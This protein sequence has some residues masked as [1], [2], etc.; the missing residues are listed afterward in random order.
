MNQ[1]EFD[2]FISYASEDRET[3]VEPLIQMLTALGVRV[4][5][6]RERL[7][8]G[9]RLLEEIDVGLKVCR[10]G[11]VI[12][13]PAF[14][15][16]HHPNR[17]LDGLLQREVG[18]EQVILPVWHE[19]DEHDIRRFSLPLANRIAARTTEGLLAVASELLRRIRPDLAEELK[20]A[21]DKVSI[22]RLPEI[23]SGHNLVSLLMGTMAHNLANDDLKTESEVELVGGFL[24]NT[25]DWCEI[26]DDLEPLDR[27][28]AEHEIDKELR[29]LKA[30]G[31]QAYGAKMDQP[32][33]LFDDNRVP[34]GHVLITRSGTKSVH[35]TETGSFIVQRGSE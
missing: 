18:G 4:W 28:R 31:W 32:L 11:V 9:Q 14:L 35:L 2:A 19:V 6:D 7:Q 30:T 3:V 25:H 34:V 8:V 27:V 13:S 23:T 12:L 21:S 16:K 33:K 17:E 26:L 5:Y 15:P 10:Y 22:I 29:N 20:A 24:Q 1:L